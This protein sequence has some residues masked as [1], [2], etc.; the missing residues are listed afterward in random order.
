[1]TTI[2]T[3]AAPA[4]PSGPGTDAP[5]RYGPAGRGPVAAVGAGTGEP[6]LWCTYAAVRTLSWLGRTDRVTEPGATAAYLLSRR[7]HDGGYA[8]SAGMA[9][10]AW[11]TF[12]CTQ[13]LH[14]LGSPPPDP[15]RSAR[16]LEQTWTGEAYGMLPG[17][18]AEVWATHFSARTA[19]LL[20]QAGGTAPAPADPGQRPDTERAPAD[21]TP[22]PTDPGQLTD[23]TPLPADP[24]QLPD[25]AR[26]PADGDRLTAWLRSLQSAD[27]GLAWTPA[28][29]RRGEADVRACFYGVLAWASAAPGSPPPWDV[30]RLV[31]WLRERQDPGG[32]FRFSPGCEVPCLW[33]TYRAT[34]ALA[35]LGAAPADP[36][37]C[38][39]WVLALRDAEGAFVRWEGYPVADVWASFCAVGTLRALGAPTEPVADAVTRR[40]AALAT[41]GG[42]YTYREPELAADA[43]TTSALALDPVTEPARRAELVRWLESCQLPNEGGVMYMP[44]RGA[45]VRCT[46]WAVA[47]GAFAADPDARAV[48][49]EWLT[50]LQNDDGGFGYW[51]GRGSDLV[52]TAS[53][54]ETLRLLAIPV[55]AALDVPALLRFTASCARPDGHYAAVPGAPP[56]LRATLQAHRVL[57]AAGE[58]SPKPELVLD[59]HRVRGGGFANEG[60]RLPDLL[61]TYDAVVA[62]ERADLAVDRAHLARFLTAVDRPDGTAWTPL[63]P[64]GG[65]PLATL[66]GTL[67][68]TRLEPGSGGAVP[69]V[70][71][72]LTLS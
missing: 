69:S 63:A 44:G 72:A 54:V 9:S 6:D 62:H 22:L 57:V 41:P 37:G 43:L 20:A 46:L 24:G 40:I 2:D 8:W 32:G 67:L 51:S 17:Q 19:V 49:A 16:W 27:G 11:A 1:M 23:T 38:V 64:G 25:T 45:E 18:G 71:P 7:N 35:A 55:T 28:H 31:G 33:A 50:G 52:S 53:A 12:Y 68:R 70:L 15:E 39:A 5:T 58:R 30:S 4:A 34:G 65:G 66:L 36:D 42:G 21:T 61:S 59:Q 26:L 48:I 56:S 13:A 3:G 60:H 10:D 47:A 14:E 29:A